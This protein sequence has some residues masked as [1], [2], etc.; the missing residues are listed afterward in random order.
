MEQLRSK[1]LIMIVGPSAVGKSTLMNQIVSGNKLYSRVRSFT[2]RPPRPND[3]PGH[4][5]YLSS[6]ELT[7][8]R[9]EAKVISEV[10]FP[11]TGQTYGTIAASYS[12]KYSLLDTL[13]NSV[14]TY[15]ALPFEKTYTI[16]L[17]T[18]AH[19]WLNW[20]KERY[21]E[22]SEERDKRLEE[23]LLSIEWSRAQ[24]NNH[25]WLINQPNNLDD[26]ANQLT[27]YIET[28]QIPNQSHALDQAAKMHQMA[29]NLLSYK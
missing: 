28:G 7:A 4:Y 1:Q 16:S 18:E 3:E 27:S 2:T 19:T 24:E 12:S 8:M 22:P 15:R 20:L 23:A 5:F 13:S 10:T 11:T 29:K 6:D 14:E 17:T 26:T 21:P 9:G 25:I